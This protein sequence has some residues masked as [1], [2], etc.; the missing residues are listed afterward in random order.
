LSLPE[1]EL[2]S[3][4]NQIRMFKEEGMFY[5]LELKRE[6][7]L[8]L[9]GL[10]YEQATLLEKKVML[11]KLKVTSYALIILLLLVLPSQAV[12]QCNTPDACAAMAKARGFIMKPASPTYKTKGCYVYSSGKYKGTAWFGL[13]GSPAQMAAPP[14]APKIR[15]TC[16]NN[17]NQSGIADGM[18]TV[19]SYNAQHGLALQTLK[20]VSDNQACSTA[21]KGILTSSNYQADE[22]S[23]FHELKV[24]NDAA[25]LRGDNFGKWVQGYCG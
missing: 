9:D 24:M 3:L 17:A 23:I 8:I 12:A 10:K 5:N 11:Q 13:G 18:P 6:K 4:Q 1:L 16:P 15:I 14:A 7:G 19:R 21:V 22:S 20:Q 25:I 2:I